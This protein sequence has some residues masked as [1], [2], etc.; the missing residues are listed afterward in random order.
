MYRVINEEVHGSYREAGKMS[1]RIQQFKSELGIS[2]SIKGSESVATP[3]LIDSMLLTKQGRSRR[4]NETRQD[5]LRRVDAKE[6]G[7]Y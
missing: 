1:S 6:I 4:E 5:V 7:G 3:Q 2:R